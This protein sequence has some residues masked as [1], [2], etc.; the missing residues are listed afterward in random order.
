MELHHNISN[1]LGGHC[2]LSGCYL[3]YLSKEEIKK[4][5]DEGFFE[6][7][8]EEKIQALRDAG[9]WND[10]P[11]QVLTCGCGVDFDTFNGIRIH[12]ARWCNEEG[13]KG[14]W[15]KLGVKAFSGEEKYQHL[16]K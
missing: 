1:P 11:Q 14:Y 7:S 12:V 5:N 16:L 2:E 6:L 8:G 10:N 9:N 15:K 3:D 4:C 13:V